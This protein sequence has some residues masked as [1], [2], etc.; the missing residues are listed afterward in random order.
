MLKNRFT[1]LPLVL[2]LSLGL[3]GAWAAPVVGESAASSSTT[4][5][6]V[7][8]TMA[9]NAWQQVTGLGKQAGTQASQVVFNAM[10]L[11]GVPYRRGG[12]S[13]LMGFD[14]S[15]FVKNVYEQALG[16]VLPRSAAEQARATEKIQKAELRPGDLVFFNTMKRA[17]SHVGIYIGDGKFIHSPSAGETVRV[18]DMAQSY[19]AKRFNGARRVLEDDAQTP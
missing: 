3:T 5:S 11:I 15:G 14:C 16:A 18:D 10:G 4:T 8:G 9:E 13:V 2:S 1:L 6:G 7:V 17:F 12:T 19:W